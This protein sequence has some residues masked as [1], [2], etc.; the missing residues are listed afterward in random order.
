MRYFLIIGLMMISS[1]AQANVCISLWWG[2]VTDVQIEIEADFNP[3]AMNERCEDGRW[4][5][6]KALEKV[7]DPLVFAAI[8]DHFELDE[9]VRGQVFK[10]MTDIQYE[11]LRLQRLWDWDEYR[12]IKVQPGIEGNPTI[13]IRDTYNDSDYIEIQRLIEG[14]P[15]INGRRRGPDYIEVPLIESGAVT[16]NNNEYQLPQRNL[17]YFLR[18]RPPNYMRIATFE[19]MYKYVT[20]VY[21]KDDLIERISD[22]VTYLDNIVSSARDEHDI[23]ISFADEDI[24]EYNQALERYSDSLAIY[25]IVTSS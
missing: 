19:S 13:H 15:T 3:L 8:L 24:D 11:T 6:E 9:E 17:A 20:A 5:V 12:E 7:R 1:F 10:F 2:P 23:S 16:I 21:D 14:N 25:N 4:P 22:I 18:L